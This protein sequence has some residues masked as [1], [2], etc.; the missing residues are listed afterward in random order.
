MKTLTVNPELCNRDGLC[1]LECPGG[2]IEP[3]DGDDLPRARDYAPE[4]CIE[5]GHCVA[6]CPTGALSLDYLSPDDCPP[7]DQDPTIDP[8]A[9]EQ[10]FKG[11]RSVRVFRR[12]AADRADLEKLI[13]IARYAPSGH[14]TQPL[15]WLVLQSREEIQRLAGL[16][17]D[18]MRAALQSQSELALTLNLDRAVARWESGCDAI[19]RDAPNMIISHAPADSRTAPASAAI[20]MAWME[21][22]AP[23]LGLGACWAGYFH[24]AATLYPPMA[25]ALDLP[26]GHQTF[27][28][29]LIGRPRLKYHRI[30]SRRRPEVEWR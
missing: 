2:L 29:L 10:W 3:P 1:A 30:P 7:L 4:R 27:G 15:S 20:S 6:V 21:L 17:V 23:S 11:R 13:D 24:A 28:S 26:E 22:S 25:Q 9:L 8:A 18:W 5:C 14:N 12:Q 19:C 16:V